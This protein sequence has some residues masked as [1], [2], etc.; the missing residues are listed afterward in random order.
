[1]I[2]PLIFEPL[3]P[4][5]LWGVR[6]QLFAYFLPKVNV[7]IMALVL[8]LSGILDNPNEYYN[9]QENCHFF[10]YPP[11]HHIVCSAKTKIHRWLLC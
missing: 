1:M 10:C 7:L 2:Y 8:I 4:L 5:N 9:F 11:A 6:I 3:N